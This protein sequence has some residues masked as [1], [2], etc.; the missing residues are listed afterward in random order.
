MLVLT[1]PIVGVCAEKCNQS[2]V[3]QLVTVSLMGLNYG[4]HGNSNLTIPDFTV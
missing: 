4:S 3:D 2:D 1:T